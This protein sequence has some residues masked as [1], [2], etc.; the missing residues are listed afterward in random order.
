MLMVRCKGL[1][2]RVHGVLAAE[3]ITEIFF[4][5]S[6]CVLEFRKTSYHPGFR[7]KPVSGGLPLPIKPLT[8]VRLVYGHALVFQLRGTDPFRAQLPITP[9]AATYRKRY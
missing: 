8:A 1:K 6:Q 7:E 3:T 9:S 4:F 5:F 2:N